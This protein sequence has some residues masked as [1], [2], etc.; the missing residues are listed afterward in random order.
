[1][2]WNLRNQAF[3]VL[4]S[5]LWLA[6]LDALNGADSAPAVPKEVAP[7]VFLLGRITDPRLTECSGVVRSSTDTNIFWVHNDGPR[8]RLYGIK[9]TGEVVAEFPVFG[10]TFSDWEDIASDGHGNLYLGDIGNNDAQRRQITV[11]QIKEPSLADSGKPVQVTRSYHLRFPGKPFDCESLFIWKEY[12]YVISKVFDDAK[13]GLYRF[14]LS[15]ESPVTL[16]FVTD[17]DITTPVTG[18]DISP[19]GTRLG[20]VGHSGAFVLRINGDPTTAGKA[21]E[22][23]IRFKDERIEGCCFIEEGLLG[24]TEN[25]EIYLFRGKGFRPK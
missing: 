7:G 13:A 12:A 8:P 5:A 6:R 10:A 23:R 1:M 22:D 24:V 15:A 2:S 16:E 20:L 21:R 14:P 25:R 3:V 17:L 19:H 4:C 9:R 11:Y 18:A